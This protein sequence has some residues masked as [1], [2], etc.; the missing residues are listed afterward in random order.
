[1]RQKFANLGVA[2]TLLVSAA[3]VVLWIRSYWRGDIVI[4]SDDSS[5]REFSSVRGMLRTQFHFGNNLH[6]PPWFRA[7]FDVAFSASE[8]TMDQRAIYPGGISIVG[9]YIHSGDH[10]LLVPHWMVAS[11]CA[12]PAGL[13]WLMRHRRF[14]NGLCRQCGYDL[15]A[16]PERCPECGSPVAPPAA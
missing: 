14:G 6:F 8:F 3:S 5:Y 4:W 11:V 9:V 7:T 12:L 15:R 16:S 10:L 13:R 1:M 2:L